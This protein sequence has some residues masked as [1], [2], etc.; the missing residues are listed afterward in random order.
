M[1]V[2]NSLSTYTQRHKYFSSNISLALR[3]ALVAEKICTVDRSNQKT[4]ENPY[5]TN[6]A[7]AIQAVAG[8]YTPALRTITDN[9]VSVNDEVIISAHVYDFEMKTMA[10]NLMANFL[11]DL[12][13]QVAFKVDQFV[14]NKILDTGTGI[15]TTAAGGFTT[16]ANIPKIMGDLL[17]KV[18]GYATGVATAPFLVVESTDLTGFFQTA[19]GSGFNYADAA[20]NNGFAGNYGG[21]KV[22]VVRTG[23]FVTETLG[24]LT[25]TN[26]GHR[27]FGITNKSVMAIPGGISYEEKS[28]GSETGKEIVAF[29]YVGTNVWFHDR[30]NFIDI[31]LA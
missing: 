13:Y 16:A 17:G 20:L 26:S 25:A 15:Y 7:A 22:Y 3:N 12:M 1:A 8:T 30:G 5:I 6:V 14:L 2:I 23:T 24:T 4:L 9:A 27:L 28:I 10:F 19:V 31:T 18:A 11:D 21:V 29:G